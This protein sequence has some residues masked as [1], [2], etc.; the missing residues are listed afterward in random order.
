MPL[1]TGTSTPAVSSLRQKRGTRAARAV[2]TG[3]PRLT[4]RGPGRR[5]LLEESI[6]P[7]VIALTRMRRSFK[8]AVHVRTSGP[9]PRSGCRGCLCSRRSRRGTKKVIAWCSWTSD[10]RSRPAE[11]GA[12]QQSRA[13][14]SGQT[15]TLPEG[16]RADGFRVPRPGPNLHV[17]KR[18][19]RLQSVTA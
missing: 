3:Q 13:E 10:G 6:G 7:G 17:G 19:G 9:P 2:R 18:S 8:S 4:G 14:S 5:L 15:F 12:S 11:A 1:S 16:A